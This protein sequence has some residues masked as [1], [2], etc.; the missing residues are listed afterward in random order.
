MFSLFSKVS[1]NQVFDGSWSPA[2]VGRVR[3]GTHPAP[4][5]L[6]GPLTLLEV[7]VVLGI[8]VRWL[9]QPLFDPS[10]PWHFTQCGLWHQKGNLEPL[11]RHVRQSTNWLALFSILQEVPHRPPSLS[12]RR[13][14][15]CGYSYQPWGLVLLHPSQKGDL[16]LSP[17]FALCAPSIGGEPQA[18]DQVGDAQCIC[19]VCGRHYHL[20]FLGPQAHSLPHRWLYTVYGPASHL[21]TLHRWALHVYERSWNLLLLRPSQ[22]NNLQC[23]IPY[24]A[25]WLPQHSWQQITRGTIWLY[26]F[27]LRNTWYYISGLCDKMIIKA[28]VIITL[29]LLKEIC[30]FYT[31]KVNVGITK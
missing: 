30:N 13:W 16:A 4:G 28:H 8:C 27:V 11:V 19:T 25:P 22:L 26:S 21:W 10:H 14:I 1:W 17:A 3:D 2:E 31:L 7:G 20:L 23:G 18:R 9:H 29:S 6:H 15:G 12:R 5:M 24:G